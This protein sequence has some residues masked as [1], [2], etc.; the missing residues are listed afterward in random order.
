MLGA[1][2]PA[3]ERVL[4][5]GFLAT[6]LAGKLFGV[7]SLRIML[8]SWGGISVAAVGVAGGES[9]VVSSPISARVEEG[10]VVPGPPVSGRVATRREGGRPPPMD[11]GGE[12]DREVWGEVDEPG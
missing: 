11:V 7:K 8:S 4:N 2:P 3:P 5:I 12:E 10:V 6:T 9:S 1:T